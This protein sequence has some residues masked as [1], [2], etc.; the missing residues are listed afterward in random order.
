MAGG[1]LITHQA[2]EPT[3]LHSLSRLSQNDLERSANE[4]GLHQLKGLL[5]RKDL[6]ADSVANPGSP[7]FDYGLTNSDLVLHSLRAAQVNLIAS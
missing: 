5:L 4:L 1:K 2:A 6:P 7:A 3:N